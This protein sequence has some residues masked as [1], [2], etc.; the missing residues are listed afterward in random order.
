MQIPQSLFAADDNSVCF[1]CRTEDKDAL[2]ATFNGVDEF[3]SITVISLSEVV[4]LYKE[5]KDRK[6]LLSQHTHF[7]CDARIMSHLYNSLGKVFATNN[8]YP[9]PIEADKDVVKA[10]RKA[11]DSTFMF[12]KGQDVSVRLSNTRL[13][14]EASVTNISTGIN[15]AVE[16]VPGGWSNVHSIHL[17]TA[18]SPSLPIFGK[19]AKQAVAFIEQK[20]AEEAAAAAAAAA[21]EAKRTEEEAGKP[22]KRSRDEVVEPKDN[23]ST[24]KKRKATKTK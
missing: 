3:G 15:G 10:L 18:A 16:K 7:L 22:K 8:K 21:V 14:Q 24:D 2:V 13:T 1:F 12:L 19:S 17:K 23:K 9:I 11:L 20:A 5:F 6:S 4:R